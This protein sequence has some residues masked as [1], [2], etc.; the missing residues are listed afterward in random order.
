MKYFIYFFTDVQNID[1]SNGIFYTPYFCVVISTIN[2]P[3]INDAW[4]R[5]EYT[6]MTDSDHNKLNDERLQRL[7]ALFN[8]ESIAFIGAT[9][10]TSKWG[11]IICN[12][13]LRGGWQG[14]LYPVNPGRDKILDLPAYPTV[15]DVPD[16]VDLAIITVPAKHIPR[17][18]DNC[19]KKQVKTGLIITAGFKEMGGEQEQAE[20]EIVA[21]AREGGMVLVG[22]NCQGICCPASRLYPHMPSHFY[23]PP[24]KVAVVSQSG[25]ILNMIIGNV[26]DA[27][28]G[29]AMGVSSG[30]EADLRLEDYLSYM[31]EHPDVESIV[32]YIESLP[33]GR[34]FFEQA[35]KVTRQK[36]VIVLKG[37]R[38]SAGQQ[39]ASS[40]TGAMAVRDEL[41]ADFCRQTGIVMA[42]TI[43]EAG[44]L[45]A[46]FVN[47]P[48][49]GGKRVAVLTGGGGLGVVAADTCADEGFDMVRLSDETIG[50]LKKLLPDW[51]VP[52][53]PVDLVA[54]NRFETL[55]PII[56]ILLKCNE[57]DAL[58]FT[59][60]GPP[61]IDRN[62]I[63][64][65][66][67]GG[68]EP[69]NMLKL[70]G[71]FIPAFMTEIQ[72]MSWETGVPVYPVVNLPDLEHLPFAELLAD[73][74]ETIYRNVE[75][76][77]RALTAMA[78]YQEYLN[79]RGE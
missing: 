35:A 5:S 29:L 37:G 57:I 36:P 49:P 43:E 50:K 7:D 70:I 67:K 15:V 1:R 8:P 71:D 11:F 17:V 41:F 24:G 10:D 18:I 56:E 14:R 20:S 62:D 58:I 28:Q 64:E 75:P 16:E 74:P 55:L 61:R 26:Y 38:T 22:P 48:L 3:D 30:N 33:D 13:V 60:V 4:K 32:A 54:G 46:S 23:P 53:N 72:K 44:I 69:P 34:R 9:E 21:R 52:G 63:P 51:W 47:R 77:C 2:D 19:V 78:N 31:A 25:N 76:A 73:S 45:G 59:F 66:E 6:A 27:G 68:M 42:D 40:H 12:S 39:A 65:E 79:R